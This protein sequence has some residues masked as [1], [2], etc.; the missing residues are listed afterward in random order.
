MKI[1][2]KILNIFNLFG[3]LINYDDDLL[4]YIMNTAKKQWWHGFN[5]PMY[6]EKDSA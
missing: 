5:T 1:I 2:L 6:K 4:N 3:S